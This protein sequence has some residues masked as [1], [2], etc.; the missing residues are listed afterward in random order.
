MS[1][2]DS[3]SQVYNILAFVFADQHTAKQVS[4][5]VKFD[6]TGEGKKV[7]STAIVE[8]DAKGKTHVHE[9]GHG[10][11][12]TAIGAVTGGLLGLI[13]GPAGL[14][15]WAVGGAVIGGIAGKHVG[16]AIPEADLKKLGQQMTPNSSALLVLAEDKDAESVINTMKGYSG[17]K[18]VT[19]TVGSEVS[20]EIATAVATDASVPESG[21]AEAKTASKTESTADAPAPAMASKTEGKTEGETE[22]PADAPAPT[23]ATT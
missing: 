3:G 20:G 8:V 18:V 13:G 19:L 11:A 21:Q 4:G 6:A 15:V 10:T 5:E 22:S 16:R 23:S 12:G 17:V 9:S 14:L 7:L 2:K 1:K